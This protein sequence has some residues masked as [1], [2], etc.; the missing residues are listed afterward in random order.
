MRNLKVADVMTEEV[1]SVR[2]D[3]PFQEVARVLTGRHISGAP[4][5]DAGGRV[6]GVVSEADLLPKGAGTRGRRWFR[7]RDKAARRTAA[8]VMT[9]PAV[10]VA[11]DTPLA[12]GARLLAKTGVKRVPVVDADGKLAGI[13]SR[14]DF[15]GVFARPDEEI[16]TEIER[17]VFERDLCIPSPAV[18]VSAGVVT[19]TG[20]VDRKSTVAIAGALTRRAAG[21]VDVENRLTFDFDDSHLRPTE[22]VNHGVLRDLWPDR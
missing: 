20:K 11:P 9:A 10:T 12:V 5:V 19:L 18:E 22:P 13:A 17:E 16:R 3:T 7:R 8:D 6:V 1:V 4:V 2:E 15:L 21:V 14:A